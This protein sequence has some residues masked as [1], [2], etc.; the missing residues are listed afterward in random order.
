MLLKFIEQTNVAVPAVVNASHGSN[1]ND[2][3]AE[4]LKDVCTPTL[5]ESLVQRA[6]QTDEQSIIAANYSPSKV[7]DVRFEVIYQ[8]N[9]ERKEKLQIETTTNIVATLD[10]DHVVDR[11]VICTFESPTNDESDLDWKVADLELERK[12]FF[13]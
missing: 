12:F 13:F 5:Y 3:T 4:F 6:K 2:E 9:G 8:D 11:N 7:T 10:S 1:F